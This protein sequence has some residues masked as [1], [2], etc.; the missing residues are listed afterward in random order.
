MKVKIIEDPLI[1]DIE[2]H[3]LCKEKTE[4][5]KHIASCIYE[6]PVTMSGRKDN[7]YVQLS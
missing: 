7:E 1:N 5:G 3:I 2:I 4:Y 6:A